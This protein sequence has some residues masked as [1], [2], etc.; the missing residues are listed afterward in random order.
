MSRNRPQ[1]EE[2][3][4]LLYLKNLYGLTG[5]LKQLG[6]YDDQNFLLITPADNKF[7]CKIS[8]A[9]TPE[10]ELTAQNRAMQLLTEA[11]PE[12]VFPQVIPNLAGQE[13]GTISDHG[14]PDCAVRVLTY[15]DG[16]LLNEDAH[17]SLS[18][19]QAFGRLLARMDGVLMQFD[20]PGTHRD[21]PW[22]LINT[23]CLRASVMLLGD[24]EKERIIHGFLDQFEEVIIPLL[25]VLR[26]SII[27][28]D[29]NDT[30]ILW[31]GD[32]PLGSQR[33]GVIDFGDLT[34]TKLV[35]EAAI[36]GAYAM[37]GKNDPIAHALAVVQGYNQ[38]LPFTER[39]SEILYL[40]MCCRICMSVVLGKRALLAE[41]GNR[42]LQLTE[43][44]GRELLTKL[45]DYDFS[46]ISERFYQ[47]CWG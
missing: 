40:L 47:A 37:L 29:A 30:N 15:L 3:Q 8:R 5:V 12:A 25:P 39:E 14:G 46:K 10:V 20:H 9:H 41:P 24:P 18:R 38:I 23:L 7:I 36:A 43:I 32:R 45:A 6:S 11:L 35:F 1:F 4:V 34:F 17:P 31:L 22:D 42:H 19:Q 13:I 33:F 2:S 44:T 26:N 16:S 28:N 27:H 21:Y